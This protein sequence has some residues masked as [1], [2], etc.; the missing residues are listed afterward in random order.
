MVDHIFN[1]A[2]INFYF[3]LSQFNKNFLTVHQLLGYS[4]RVPLFI[5][6][7]PSGLVSKF[8]FRERIDD[9]LRIE[10]K[11]RQSQLNRGHITK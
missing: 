2:N 4:I 9:G 3:S 11:C 1:D 10:N 8:I 7:N 5:S 6:T